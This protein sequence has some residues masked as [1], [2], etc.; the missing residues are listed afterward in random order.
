MDPKDN[1]KSD[2]DRE[3]PTSRPGNNGLFQSTQR[4]LKGRRNG[5]ANGPVKGSKP[6][7][8]NLGNPTNSQSLQGEQK[9]KKD[10]NQLKPMTDVKNN[11]NL[12]DPKGGRERIPISSRSGN[13]KGKRRFGLGASGKLSPRRGDQVGN[14]VDE[15]VRPPEGAIPAPFGGKGVPK[16]IQYV[17][18]E[19][20]VIYNQ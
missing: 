12:I 17:F 11:P 9:L 15:E 14:K 16:Q 18:V 3:S 10:P 5:G 19:N 6:E 20:M 7:T 13:G 1:G 4:N 2:L 8:E